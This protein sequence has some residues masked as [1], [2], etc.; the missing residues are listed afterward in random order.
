MVMITHVMHMI[1]PWKR[2]CHI[3][4]GATVES[5]LGSPEYL[6]C[7]VRSPV[8]P[9]TGDSV[10]VSAMM[11]YDPQKRRPI[12]LFARDSWSPGVAAHES[13]HALGL[14]LDG[15]YGGGGPCFST[16]LT[17]DTQEV[18]A[19]NLEQ[20][21]DACC[22]AVADYDAGTTAVPP[23]VPPG[24]PPGG[25]P[26]WGLCYLSPYRWSPPT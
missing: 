2:M 4:V 7:P 23:V 8:P 14:V 10:E 18:C 20:L 22:S 5:V 17:T 16:P 19:Y 24:G 3:Y 12:L 13:L 6:G 1:M 25:P 15:M 11:T 21:V 26:R 9:V